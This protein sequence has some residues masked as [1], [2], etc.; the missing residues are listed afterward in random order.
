MDQFSSMFVLAL[1]YATP[2]IIASLG[3]LYSE[4]SGIV[5]IGIEGIML[6]GA[7]VAAAFVPIFENH[8]IRPWLA[9]F[10]TVG[11]VYS[12]IHAYI[13]SSGGNRPSAYSSKLSV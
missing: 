13:A 2:I 12:S 6:V 3:G 7:F 1:N 10:A 5:N 11:E 4:R 9:F 8:W